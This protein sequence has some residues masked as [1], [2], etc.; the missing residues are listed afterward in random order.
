MRIKVSAQKKSGLWRVSE[1]RTN[2]EIFLNTGGE[3]VSQRGY[4]LKKAE[5][6]LLVSSEGFSN[7]LSLHSNILSSVLSVRETPGFTSLGN[8]SYKFSSSGKP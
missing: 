6:S 8:L 4:S 3:E 2:W 5:V 7:S 1:G